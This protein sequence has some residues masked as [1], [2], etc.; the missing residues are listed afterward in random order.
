ML[1]TLTNAQREELI[2]AVEEWYTRTASCKIYYDY[3]EGRIFCESKHS[4][5]LH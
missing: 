1:L 3:E 5:N 4:K 2:A